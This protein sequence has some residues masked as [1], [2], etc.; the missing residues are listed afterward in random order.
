MKGLLV[1]ILAAAVGYVAYQYVYPPLADAM[2]FE[3]HKPKVVEAPPPPKKEEPKVEPPKPVVEAPKVE[4][5]VVMEAPPPPPPKPVAP[6]VDPNAF[7]PPNFDPIEV[8]TK[9]WTVIP[10]SAFTIPKAVTVKKD[11]ELSMKNGAMSAA[12]NIKSGGT[13]YAVGFEA[14]NLLVAPAA[15]SPMRGQVAMDD[16]NFRDVLTQFYEQVK[17]V[18]I[19]NARKAHVAKLAAAERAKNAPAATTVAAAGSSAKPARD[20][21][22]T[23]PLLVASMKSGQV[24]EIKP[25]KIKEWGEAVFADGMW[26]VNVKYENDT[27]FGKFEIEAQAQIKN[28]KVDKWIYTGSGEVVP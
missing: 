24:T 9:N 18:Q 11:M 1:L 6:P 15:G 22:G 26:T 7:V 23:Y 4:P 12:T 2:K 5:K 10:A 21:D 27:M 3:K 17:V 25:D 28:G 13:L 19:E 16:T 8:V 14:G 20:K